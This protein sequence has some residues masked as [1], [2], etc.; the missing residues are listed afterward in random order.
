[1]PADHILEQQDQFKQAIAL[2]TSLSANQQLV[3]FGIKPTR[4]ETGYGYIKAGK[5]VSDGA[6]HV[7]KFVEK[8]ALDKAQSYVE[9][10][11]YSWNSGM[12]MFSA[13]TLVSEL[14][15]YEPDIEV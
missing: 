6:Y 10:G 2:A 12:F 14:A 1:M 9:S 3:T 7:E 4:P 15:K 13:A 5:S 8:P 11:E